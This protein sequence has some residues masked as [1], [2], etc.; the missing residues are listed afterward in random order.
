MASAIAASS[1]VTTRSTTRF[2]IAKGASPSLPTARPSASVC[3]RV[4]V[5]GASCAS[6]A[7]RH[8]A[9]SGSTP[10]I[11]TA[12]AFALTAMPM[13]AMQAAAADR[14]DDRFDVRRL[15]EDLEAHRA[16][17]RDHVGVVERMNERETVARGDLARVGARLGQ[18][19]TVQHDVG[20]ELAAVGHLD[21]RREHAASP[22]SSGMP[23]SFA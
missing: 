7:V 9:R 6:A 14:H 8:A 10:T 15:L 17:T 13:P 18:V 4:T 12:G 21:Q 19:R 1:T 23:S 2:T 3:D 5:V 11:A 16:L 22:R 20:A